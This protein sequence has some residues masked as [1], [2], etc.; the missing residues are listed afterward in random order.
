MLRDLGRGRA[1]IGAMLPSTNRNLEPDFF[2]LAPEGVSVHFVRLP[3]EDPGGVPDSAAQERFARVPL[4]EPTKMH[5]YGCHGRCYRL[6][7]HIGDALGLGQS[8]CFAKCRNRKYLRPAYRHR[9]KGFARGFVG[10]R[11]V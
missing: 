10:A 3:E 11:R 2:L 8:R 1:R 5:A 9:G 4:Q 6:R 7:V